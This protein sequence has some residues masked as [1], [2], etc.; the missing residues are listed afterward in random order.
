[1]LRHNIAAAVDKAYSDFNILSRRPAGFDINVFSSIGEQVRMANEARSHLFIT[2]GEDDVTTDA[3]PAEIQE[4]QSLQRNDDLQ[5]K[6]GGKIDKQEPRERHYSPHP[7][8]SRVDNKSKAQR[9]R[10][11]PEIK[12]IDNQPSDVGAD[13]QEVK[14]MSKTDSSAV[15]SAQKLSRDD[16]VSKLSKSAVKQRSQALDQNDIKSDVS[17]SKRDKK[18][19]VRTDVQQQLVVGK[20]SAGNSETKLKESSESRREK[21]VQS[22]SN[23]RSHS[24]GMKSDDRKV[25]SVITRPSAKAQVGS[26]VGRNLSGDDNGCQQNPGAKFQS[27][28]PKDDGEVS[29]KVVLSFDEVL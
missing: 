17:K 24:S 6:S 26:T 15:V 13:K 29:R 10:D 5:S 9:N 1:M 19:G 12:R 20:L 16:H 7:P 21:K 23:T 3:L 14:Q 8:R 2:P 11:R 4:S 25:K 18:S 22:H 27:L 28:S